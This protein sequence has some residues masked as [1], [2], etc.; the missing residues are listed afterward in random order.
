MGR[1]PEF[2]LRRALRG[3]LVVVVLVAVAILAGRK[4]DVAT[5]RSLSFTWRWI[6][7]SIA[8]NTCSV[9]LKASVWDYVLR[10][11]PSPLKVPFRDLVRAVFIGLCL[12]T[13]VPGR[14][15]EV[16]RVGTVKRRHPSAPVPVLVGSVVGEHMLSTVAVVSLIAG[17]L[18]GVDRGVAGRFESTLVGLL[19]VVV[20]LSI[21]LTAIILVLQSKRLRRR[22]RRL[23]GRPVGAVRLAR[24]VAVEL[25]GGVAIFRRGRR[26]YSAW[27]LAAA[28]ASSAAQVASIFAA[29]S[30]VGIDASLARAGAAF[31]ASSLVG[32]FPLIPGNVGAFQ[33]VVAASLVTYNITFGLGF[34]FAIA[35]QALEAIVGVGIGGWLLLRE[36]LSLASYRRLEQDTT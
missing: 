7:A 17:L 28:L 19:L 6:V 33:A 4:V 21:S 15:G 34:A 22:F 2:A 31:I 9:L 36:G 16:A 30:A 20:A 8:F 26:T 18:L 23:G 29:L 10:G 35:L 32:I 14:V 12:N 11:M 24:E 27:A 25:R 13:L 1:R 3:A 5:L